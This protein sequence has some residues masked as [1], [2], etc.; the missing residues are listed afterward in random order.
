MQ[1]GCFLSTANDTSAA[2]FNQGHFLSHK[3]EK[4]PMQLILSGACTWRR[5]K[6]PNGLTPKSLNSSLDS[7]SMGLHQPK[8]AA[9]VPDDSL[10]R[11]APPKIFIFQAKQAIFHPGKVLPSNALF[12]D[13]EAPFP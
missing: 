2:F 7:V 3:H 8:M 13:D 10:F 4:L 1:Q 9:L 12:I 5:A 6:S 11:F